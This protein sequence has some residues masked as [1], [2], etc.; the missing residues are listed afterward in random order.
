MK[1]PCRHLCFI[2]AFL[3]ACL[4]ASVPASVRAQK[5]EL[6][7]TRAGSVWKITD[8]DNTVY[9]AGSVHLL[10][11]EDHPVSPVYDEAYADSG[12]IVFEVDMAE[13][14]SPEGMQKMQQ[15]GMYPADDSLDKHLKP[16]TMEQIRAYLGSH[17]S[18]AMLSLALPR[19]KPGMVFLSIS[20]LEAMR[21]KARPDL[22]LESVYFQKARADGKNSRGLET[23]EFQMSLFDDFTDSEIDDLL[24]KT[25]KDSAEMPEVLEQLIAHWHT[26]D[27]EALDKL[28]NDEMQDGGEK[29]KEKLLTSRNEN[30]IPEIE[31]AIKGDKNVMFLVGAGHLVGEEG[32]IEM[33]RKKGHSVEKLKPVGKVLPVQQ[34][35]KKAA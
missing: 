29:L 33:L 7:A 22:G 34:E 27:S 25:L 6:A 14:T 12:E 4:A 16:E 10:R 24:A 15:L 9:L 1:I 17:E 28:L 23:L 21:L 2:H 20:S 5:S 3:L 18:G 13:M 35:R 30:W 31:K 19:L 11:E 8:G 32:V 26:G